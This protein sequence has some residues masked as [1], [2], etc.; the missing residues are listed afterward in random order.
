MRYF[1]Y[2]FL[3]EPEGSPVSQVKVQDSLSGA[4][5][6]RGSCVCRDRGRPS[7]TGGRAGRLGLQAQQCCSEEEMRVK[8][9]K[10]LKIPNLLLPKMLVT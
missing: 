9:Y 7:C 8:F 2:E 5:N 10:I 3:G 6:W 1:T 4:W